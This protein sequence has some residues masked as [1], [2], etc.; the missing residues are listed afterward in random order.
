[1]NKEYKNIDEQ[2]NY[3]VTNKKINRLTIDKD[4]L[5]KYSYL[6]VVTPFTDLIAIG[7]SSNNEHMYI[8]NGSFSS[9]MNMYE[10]DNQICNMLRVLIGE[11]EKNLKS[12]LSDVY[13]S[14]LHA[15]KSTNC[16]DYSVFENY[17][18]SLSNELNL[19]DINK[20]YNDKGKMS[21]S[22]ENVVKKRIDVFKKIVELGNFS[23]GK[24]NGILKHYK[25]KGYLPFWVVIHS[26]TLSD[27]IQLF[28]VLDKS[29]KISFLILLN[30]EKGNYNYRDINRYLRKF[31][32]L[33]I[34]RNVVNHYEPITPLITNMEKNVFENLLDAIKLVKVNLTTTYT[35]SISNMQL[36]SNDYNKNKINK[37]KEIINVLK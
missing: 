5:R 23:N 15:L 35:S 27:L 1:M 37:I 18:Q 10:I 26:L 6:S 11:F 29:T 20:E 4:F 16:S 2:I 19:I 33:N 8:D 34:V 3:L 17:Y 30:P 12:Y 9:F 36:I 31:I 21:N 28:D 25:N 32:S 24:N 13:C 7:R 14:K 22:S